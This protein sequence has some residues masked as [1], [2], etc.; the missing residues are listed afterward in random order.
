MDKE[1]KTLEAKIEALLF[2]HGEPMSIKKLA[3]TIKVDEKKIEN[4]LKNFGEN[5]NSAERGLCLILH[6]EKA[7]LS[8]SPDLSSL[9]EKLTKEEL[10]TK[11]TPASLETLSIIA[12]LGPCTRALI[13]HIRGVNSS[14]ILRSLMV[15]GLVERKSDP[16]RLNAYVYQPTFDFLNHVGISSQN[17]LPKYEEYKSVVESFF[18]ENGQANNDN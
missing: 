8:T 9:L 11:L 14:F 6:D 1:E 15:R 5:L 2:I 17:D 4:A 10:D 12:Y 16:K 7:Q 13:E 18:Q 3:D